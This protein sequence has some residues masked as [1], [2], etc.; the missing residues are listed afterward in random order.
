MIFNY[1]KEVKNIVIVGLSNKLEW[2]SYMVV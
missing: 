1:L 2:I